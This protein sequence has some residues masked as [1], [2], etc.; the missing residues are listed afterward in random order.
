LFVFVCMIDPFYV[1]AVNPFF[2]T[3]C[4]MIYHMWWYFKKG[5]DRG[6]EGQSATAPKRQA[7]ERQREAEV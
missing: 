7:T 1:L 6:T 2:D 4:C 5:T 3:T